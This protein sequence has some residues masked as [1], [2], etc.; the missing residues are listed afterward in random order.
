MGIR[1]GENGRVCMMV[2]KCRAARA[3]LLERSIWRLRML[4]LWLMRVVN[5]RTCMFLG[6]AAG[7]LSIINGIVSIFRQRRRHTSALLEH[8]SPGRLSDH[9]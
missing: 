2:L 7:M 5:K 8:K 1:G 6:L 4:Q 9:V 3:S